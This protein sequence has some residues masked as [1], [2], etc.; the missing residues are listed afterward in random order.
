MTSSEEYLP[1]S[2]IFLRVPSPASIHGN[3]GCSLGT[4][5]FG[6]GLND[7]LASVAV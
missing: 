3:R 4:L 2:P 1:R 5:I 6:F 7:R